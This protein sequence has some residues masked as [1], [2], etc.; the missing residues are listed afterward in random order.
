MEQYVVQAAQDALWELCKDEA[1][2]RRLQN[3]LQRLCL[4]AN[5]EHY[6]GSCSLEVR[7][8]L[9]RAREIPDDSESDQIMWCV[10]SAVERIFSDAGR[11]D[12]RVGMQRFRS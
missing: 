2:E 3:A 12:I 10:M 8:V 1:R 7:D 6:L 9:I 4:A 5:S 11:L